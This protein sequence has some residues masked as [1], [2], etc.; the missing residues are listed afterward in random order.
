MDDNTKSNHLSSIEES[1]EIENII[2]IKQPDLNTIEHVKDAIQSK[3]LLFSHVFQ[4]V[5]HRKRV[6]QGIDSTTRKSY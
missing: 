3:A 2:R 6:Q 1:L 5:H 4:N